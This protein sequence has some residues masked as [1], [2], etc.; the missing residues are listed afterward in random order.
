MFEW[1]GGAQA[2][3][4]KEEPQLTPG[5][6]QDQLTGN[7]QAKGTLGLGVQKLPSP[8]GKTYPLKTC[9][10]AQVEDPLGRDS[11]ARGLL[12]TSSLP[13][14]SPRHQFGRGEKPLPVPKR[15]TNKPQ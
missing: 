1:L 14:P 6:T 2:A 11:Q 3:H 7:P 4:F 8:R 12:G 9:T 13:P 5:S 10:L 15:T